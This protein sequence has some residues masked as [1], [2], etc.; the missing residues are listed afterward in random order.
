MAISGRPRQTMI[1]IGAGIGAL[2]TG[3]YAQMNGYRSRVFELHDVP[4]G[5][6]A[7]WKRGEFSFDACMSWLLGS[8]PGNELYQI[9]LELGALHGKEIRHFEMFNAVET[10]TGHIVRFY[11]DPDRLQDHLTE[12]SPVDARRIAEFCRGLRQFQSCVAAVPFL[13]PIG[14][15]GRLE[16]LRMY[17]RFAPFHR[18]ITRSLTTR[19]ADCAARFDSP[20]LREAFNYVLYDRAP[21]RSLLAFYF[22][23]AHH[24]NRAAGVPEGGWL[25]VA[26]SIEARYLALGGQIRYRACVDEILVDHDRAIGVRLSDGQRHLADMVVVAGDGHREILELVRGLPAAEA[27]PQRCADLIDAPDG[28][29]TGQFTLFLGLDRRFPEAEHCTTHLLT[30]DEAAELPGIVH[31]SIHVEF[32]NR[33]YPE[34]SPPGSSV[35]IASYGCDIARWRALHQ[36]EDRLSRQRRGIEVRTI[37]SQGASQGAGQRAGQRGRSYPQEKRRVAEFLTDYLDRKYPGVA[38]A[39]VVRDVSSP[40]TQLRCAGQRDDAAL[41]WQPFGE[42]GDLL[43]GAIA[44]VPGLRNLYVAEAGGATGGLIR[45]AAAGRHVMQFIC[46][47]DRKRF[48]AWVDD[49]AAP[50]GHVIVPPG[51]PRMIG[52]DRAR[53]GSARVAPGPGLPAPPAATR[54][55]A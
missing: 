52:T 27:R 11:S 28:G 40:L 37:A 13:K 51:G 55:P 35:M 19:M 49:A 26:R 48:V 34:L 18:A 20:V 46:R 31:P 54:R 10:A 36:G 17:L 2:S 8:G 6:S 16:R 22:P 12:L 30:E 7:G 39:L 1:I 29:A 42:R 21:E 23:L 45:A 32:R 33:H 43:D 53:P 50:P 41:S 3:C 14:L 15:M 9:W 47:D 24:A 25:G 38:R 5:C 44:A 4:G